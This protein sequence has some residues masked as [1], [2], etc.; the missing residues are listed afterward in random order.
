MKV[1]IEKK[2]VEKIWSVPANKIGID[3]DGTISEYIHSKGSH[4]LSLELG[5]FL[6]SFAKD[7]DKQTQKRK[8]YLGTE[9][10]DCKQFIKI[11]LIKTKF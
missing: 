7:V 11:D 9:I 8:Y 2:L 10:D 6:K 1:N 5:R 4:N 3:A